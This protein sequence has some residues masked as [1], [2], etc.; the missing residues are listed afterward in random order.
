MEV[1]LMSRSKDC[2]LT[3]QVDPAGLGGDE[4]R[5]LLDLDACRFLALLH[6]NSKY[7]VKPLVFKDGEDIYTVEELRTYTSQQ[8]VCKVA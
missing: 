8:S 7:R 3:P 5:G 4:E 1:T 2:N 6:A